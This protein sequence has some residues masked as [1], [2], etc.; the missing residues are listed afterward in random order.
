MRYCTVPVLHG[1]GTARN[2]QDLL[3][4]D[5]KATFP[6]GYDVVPVEIVENEDSDFI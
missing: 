3:G 4:R 1:C 2:I 5:V 6:D